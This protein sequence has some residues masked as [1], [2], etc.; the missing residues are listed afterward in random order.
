MQKKLI[1]LAVASVA[2]SLAA[3]AFAQTNVTISGIAAVTFESLKAGGSQGGSGYDMPSRNRVTS[4]SSYLGFR[5]TEDL[6][7]G[8]NAIFQFE[9]SIGA[10]GYVPGAST[11]TAAAGLFGAPRDTFVGLMSKTLGKITLGVH[12]GPY[13]V[14]GVAMDPNPGAT[15][16]GFN[17]ALMGAMDGGWTTSG[18]D[19]R[20]ASSVMYVSPSINGLTVSAI[21]GA[22]E[23]RRETNFDGNFRNDHTWGAGLTYANG[24]IYVGYAYEQRKQRDLWDQDD[25]FSGHRIGG[26]YTIASGMGNTTIGLEWDRQKETE[27]GSWDRRDA[28][29]LSVNHNMGPHQIIAQFTKAND[30]KCSGGC[31]GWNSGAKMFNLAYNYN[32][33]K[34]T[35]IKTYF[36]RISNEDGAGYDFYNATGTIKA[37][38]TGG[39]GGA[40]G[41]SFSNLDN[42]QDPQGFGIGIRHSF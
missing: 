34:R 40:N 25:K 38:S 33:S 22:N 11:I 19:N 42:G 21:Y 5:G 17:G 23:S 1:A 31:S 41:G 20:L 13:R 36:A 3:P 8:L 9:T 6:G 30:V 29:N 28:W 24:P 10:D 32:L 4:N 14:L 2:A 37:Q 18:L 27:P 35:M 39:I 12:S 7:N 26:K 16:I 15:G